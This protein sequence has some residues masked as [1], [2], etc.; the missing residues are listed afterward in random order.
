MGIGSFT[1]GKIELNLSFRYHAQPAEVEQWK[2]SFERASQMLF[3][4]TNGTARI[5]RIVLSNDS[6][7]WEEADAWLY[8]NGNQSSFGHT[9]TDEGAFGYSDVHMTLAINAASSPFQILHELGHYVFTLGDE[10]SGDGTIQCTANQQ[11]APGYVDSGGAWVPPTGTEH[12]CI[13][14]A[15]PVASWNYHSTDLITYDNATNEWV[16]QPGWITEFCTKANHDSDNGS[17]HNQLHAVPGTG[18]AKGR[19]CQEVMTALY[20]V[21]V[22]SGAKNAELINDHDVIW[23]QA[24]GTWSVAPTLDAADWVADTGDGAPLM[25]SAD[26]FRESL[27]GPKTFVK[28]VH[29]R[30]APSHDTPTV[31]SSIDEAIDAGRNAIMGSGRRAA[32]QALVLFS[33]GQTSISD[34]VELGRKLAGDGIRVLALGLGGDR[35]GLQQVAEHSRGTYFEIDPERGAHLISD[36]VMNM[37][38]QLRYGAPICRVWS[39]SVHGDESTPTVLVERGSKGLKLL[40]TH[41]RGEDLQLVVTRPSGAFLPSEEREV[42]RF[43]GASTLWVKNPEPGDWEVHV[44]PLIRGNAVKYVLTAYSENP[45]LHVGVSGAQRVYEL[46]ERINLH[47]VI[48][49]P[50]PVVGLAGPVARVTPPKQGGEEPTSRTLALEPRQGGAYVFSFPA[51]KLGAYEVEIEVWN[52]GRA[53]PAGLPG[54]RV[55]ATDPAIPAFRRMKRFQ[56]HVGVAST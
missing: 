42:T 3:N 44:E 39:D 49:S 13:M 4:A 46:G 11:V 7:G 18:G 15:T 52:E 14:G 56:V 45:Q 20:P 37:A 36:Q 28:S 43:E 23:E 32:T 22:V 53:A 40:L 1:N 10:Y 33:T 19:S 24:E 16:A 38:D 55:D 30:A 34:P 6:Y 2:A 50:M 5:S 31:L 41:P 54:A 12:A 25:Q 51:E 35:V 27:A 21:H 26:Y 17:S 29:F 9:V 48:S 47:V 8:P